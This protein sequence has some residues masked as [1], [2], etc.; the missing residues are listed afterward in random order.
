LCVKLV[1]YKGYTEMHGL[2]NIK[3]HKSLCKV[4]IILARL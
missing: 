1:I 2:Q 3:L 4:P